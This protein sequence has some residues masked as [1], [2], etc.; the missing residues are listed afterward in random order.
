MKIIRGQTLK[1]MLVERGPFGAEEAAVIGRDLCQALAAV[2]ARGLVHRD[3]KAQNVMR[4]VGGQT[5]LMDFGAGQHVDAVHDSLKGSPAYVAP[6]VLAGA[7]ATARS[8]IYSLGVLLFHLVTG[9]FPVTASTW[10]E[11]R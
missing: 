10:D 9:D 4:E 6:E 2:H 7:P 5:I 8:D 1:E 3:V 11:L